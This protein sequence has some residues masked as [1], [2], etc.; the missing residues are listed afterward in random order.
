MQERTHKQRPGTTALWQTAAVALCL[1]LAVLMIINTQLSGEAMW[2]WYGTTFRHGAKIYSGLHTALQ[3]FFVLET[4]TWLRLFGNNLIVYEIPSLL[5]AFLLMLG[6]V[7]ILRESPWPDRWKAAALLGTFT[8]IVAGHSY[9]FDDYH[10]VAEF[11]I[12]YALLVLLLLGK[13][14]LRNNTDD[15]SQDTRRQLK[16]TALLG[17]ICGLTWTTRVTDGAALITASAL[18]LPVLLRKNRLAALA[19]F[20]LTIVLTIVITVLLTG[21]SFSAYLSNSIFRAAASKGGTG[22]IFAAP[23]MTI[24][25]T[26]PILI[27][28]KKVPGLLIAS[29]ILGA[30]AKRFF[31]RRLHYIIPLQLAFA[32]LVFFRTS[33]KDHLDLK[34]GMFY[35]NVVLYA[36]LLMYGFAVWVLVRMFRHFREGTPW[37]P[38]EIVILLPILEWASYS[39]GAAAEPLTNY[40]APVALLLLLI[41][42]LQPFR[43]YA[44]W[45]NP[46]VITLFLLLT[47]NVVASKIAIP[48]SWQNY[49]Y[50]PMFQGRVSFHH[51][52]YGHM[53]I[54]RDLLTFSQHLCKDIGAQPGINQPELLSLPYPYPNYF[55]GTA[56]WHNYVQTFFDTTTRDTMAH[57]QHELETDPPQW[58]V[59]QRQMN[60]MIGSERLYNHSQPIPQRHLDT[61]I[62]QKLTSG[63]WT[64]VDDSDY[65]LPGDPP[66]AAGA[67]WYV[68]R[69]QRS[70]PSAPAPTPTP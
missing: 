65:L 35:E 18:C 24:V 3:P 43:R 19:L 7:F 40:Y 46:S 44:A 21:D 28:Y 58:I 17:L 33:A 37:D 53:Y 63:E 6:I 8:F 38:R 1:T 9:R 22:S 59:Y 68:I 34:R 48:Y 60:I 16:L 52:L 51:P 50:Q 47:V 54:D 2:F 45:A 49:R 66:S 57:L 4:G 64:L 41:P 27:M 20:F 39:A 25:N 29:A 67:G 42:V 36:T 70:S 26:F 31:P 15:T 56:P 23:F 11:Q 61:F 30:L 32:A 14:S 13:P 69:T 10:V 5:H 62:A 55:C 12:T